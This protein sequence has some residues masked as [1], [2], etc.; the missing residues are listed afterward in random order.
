MKHI[1]FIHKLLG[2]LV[3]VMLLVSCQK[4]VLDKTPLDRI[5]GSV[6][7]TDESL[8]QAY[9]YNLYNTLPDGYMLYEQYGGYGLYIMASITDEARTKSVWIDDE[10][11]VVPGLISPTND[12]VDTWG[13]F[14]TDIRTANALIQGMQTSPLAQAFKDRITSEARFIRAVDY[15]NLARSY[16]DVPLIT[17]PQAINDTKGILVPRT[18]VKDVY[19]FIDQELEAIGAILP[20]AATL[21]SSEYGRATREAAW[22]LDGRVLLYAKSYAKSA[23]YSKKVMDAGIFHLD[24]DYN[25]LFQS[26]GGSPEAIFEIL[27]NGAQKGHDFDRYNVPVPYGVDYASQTNPTQEMVDTYEM[28]N[29]LAITDPASGYDP[30]NP[31]AGRDSRLYA[32]IFYQG[33]A[34]FKGNVLDM[35]LPDGAQAPLRTG[36]SSISGYYIR[37]FIDESVA[38]AAAGKSMTSWKEL[39][40]GEVLLN[41]AEAQNEAAGPD[42]SIYDAINAVRTRAHVANIPSGLTQVAMRQRIIHERGVEL[43]FE[44]FRWYDLIR[45]NLSVS[46]LNNKYFH[47]MNVTRDANGNLVYDPTVPLNF[48]AKQVFQTKNYLLP[49]PQ[50]EI[51]INPNLTQ[52]P[53]Y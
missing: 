42:P 39:R 20:S 45:W 9:L 37:K 21:P 6:V 1:F 48:H 32:S 28:S 35:V 29:G 18:P 43:A 8:T 50:S 53:G 27:F 4:S 13:R 19:S 5:A 30:N 2:T 10:V 47:G 36:L 25:A 12:P 40:L 51:N 16:G 46:V 34:T 17:V 14:Y 24:P 31:Y 49:I 33:G 38:S 7:F 26:H 11:S 41:Y 44:N 15:F 23:V 52:N 22:A 3:F